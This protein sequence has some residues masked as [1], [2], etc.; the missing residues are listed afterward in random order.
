MEYLAFSAYMTGNIRRALKL[1]K[2]MVELE[3]EHPR[4]PGNL[5][6]YQSTLEKKG[7]TLQKRGEDG[8]GDADETVNIIK[9]TQVVLKFPSKGFFAFL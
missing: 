3:P 5:E 1:T 2:Q 9:V 7:A 8:L 6:Y 4:G